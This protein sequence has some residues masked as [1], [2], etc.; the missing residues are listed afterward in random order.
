MPEK[1]EGDKKVM[2]VEG[3]GEK[4]KEKREKWD[5]EVKE[6]QRRTGKGEG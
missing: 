2:I 1:M 3:K 4:D 6:S 5:K